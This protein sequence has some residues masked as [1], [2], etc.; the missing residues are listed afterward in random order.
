MRIEPADVLLFPYLY[1]YLVT[2]SP[3]TRLFQL[4]ESVI[5]YWLEHAS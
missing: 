3:T 1:Q 5:E 2:T 4:D